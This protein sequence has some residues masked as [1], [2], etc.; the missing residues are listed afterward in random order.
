M[1]GSDS[2]AYP[3]PPWLLRGSAIGIV[4]LVDSAVAARY[5]PHGLKVV[6]V[7]P[8][9]TLGG[10]LLATY[11]PG[12]T[13]QYHELIAFSGLAR[14]GMRVGAW[15]SH[16]YV[17]DPLSVAGGREIWGLPKELAVF[18]FV[19]DRLT[20]SQSGCELM[21]VQASGRSPKLPAPL[22]LPAWGEMGRDLLAFSACGRAWMLAGRA[23]WS[24]SPDSPLAAVVAS[25]S[26]AC[27]ELQNLRLTIRAPRRFRA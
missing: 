21:A 17:D 9:R 18:H 11:G 15:I 27:L 24:A 5:L 1:M 8:G 12:S 19:G 7:L 26:G 4:R 23:H 2:P 22:W 13:L 14:R 6:N 10:L 3:A 16:I 25:G 20:V